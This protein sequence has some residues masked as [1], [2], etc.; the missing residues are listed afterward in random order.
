MTV[1]G[2]EKRHRTPSAPAARRGG[3]LAGGPERAAAPAQARVAAGGQPRAQRERQP[4]RDE[5]GA[6]ER[7]GREAPAKRSA[8]AER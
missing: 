1:C 6:G 5:G 4:E 8:L 3:R 2:R 7:A